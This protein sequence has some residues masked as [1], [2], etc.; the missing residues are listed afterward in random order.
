[1]FVWPLYIQKDR[2]HDL[3]IYDVH[4]MSRDTRKPVFG[5]LTRFDTNRAVH[6]KQMTRGLKFQIY[7]VEGL[8]YLRSKNKGTY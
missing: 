1:M 8:Y 7:E 5:I 6:P 2:C 4:I 3:F